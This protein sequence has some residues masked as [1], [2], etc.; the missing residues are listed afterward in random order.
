M[1]TDL[2]GWFRTN[3]FTEKKIIRYLLSDFGSGLY[4]YMVYLTGV[5]RE[6]EAKLMEDFR[7]IIFDARDKHEDGKLTNIELAASMKDV[8]ERLKV[9]I[10]MINA[11]PIKKWEHQF[12][13]SY[14]N[15]LCN[16][17]YMLN[18]NKTE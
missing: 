17:I 10:V 16:F 2:L 7:K 3:S 1:N 14:T 4:A 12:F 9:Q 18:P 13:D 11:D 15:E 5:G 8:Y 6:T